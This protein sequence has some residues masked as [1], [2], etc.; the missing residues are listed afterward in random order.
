MRA[1]A[2][3]RFTPRRRGVAIYVTSRFAIFKHALTSE[4]DSALVQVPQ[5][6]YEPVKR[7]PYYAAYV[8]C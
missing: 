1:R 5:A 4:S 3:P 7:T 2:D 8:A 6:G